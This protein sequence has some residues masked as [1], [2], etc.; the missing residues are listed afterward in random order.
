RGAAS[1]GYPHGH[2]PGDERTSRPECRREGK[3]KAGALENGVPP[4]RHGCGGRERSEERRRG[5]AT[6]GGE[7][8]R[9]GKGQAT[10]GCDGESGKRSTS[11]A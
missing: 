4:G 5:T 9:L 10:S 1:S 11:G 8:R 3:T 2:G 7:G 6:V